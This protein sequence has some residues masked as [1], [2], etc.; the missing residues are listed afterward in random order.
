[1]VPWP[2]VAM[3][4]FILAVSA[5]VVVVIVTQGDETLS[6]V[7][8][9][10]AIIAFLV[11]IIV[12]IVQM[13]VASEQ[14]LQSQTIFGEMQATLGTIQERTQGTQQ[15]LMGLNERLMEAALGK[16]LPQAQKASG[17]SPD[18]F[19]RD[20]AERLVR[21]LREGSTDPPQQEPG[22]DVPLPDFPS[23]VSDTRDAE[24]VHQLSTFPSAEAARTSLAKLQN[25]PKLSL[26]RLKRLAR[27]E[28]RSRSPDSMLAPGLPATPADD[29]LIDAG[30]VSGSE[31]M[32][33]GRPL[34]TLTDQGREAAR[35]LMADGAL[36]EGV[37]HEL[38]ASLRE[39][40]DD[41]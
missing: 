11:Q 25:L 31:K 37:D 38:F 21:I 12:F 17:D 9:I 40:V 3:A 20:T 36:P 10:L 22:R 19:V 18:E 23:R 16:V 2:A 39:A 7:A 35:L 34:R 1:M 29:A 24:I 4:S 33:L 14:S 30:L 26:R 28:R 27:D 32:A 15:S 5:G 41:A 8:I 6:T 13:Q